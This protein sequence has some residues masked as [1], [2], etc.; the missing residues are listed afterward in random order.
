M[1]QEPPAEAATPQYPPHIK[2]RSSFNPFAAYAELP[3]GV[4]YQ[5][6]ESDEIIEILLRRHPITNLR[7]QIPALLAI[8]LPLLFIAVPLEPLGLE[9]LYQVPAHIRVILLLFWYLVVAGYA[10][11]NFLIWYFNVYFVTNKRVVDVDFNGLMHYS[12]NEVA[13]HQIQDVEHKQV[14]IWQMLFRYGTVHIQT[15]ATKQNLDF[16]KVPLPARVADIVTDLLPIPTDVIRGK[17][18]RE[19][20]VSANQ[21]GAHG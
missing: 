14:G 12:S 4:T 15:S 6:Q 16:E 19:P 17:V 20:K 18:S 9:A 8:L 7:W 5:D 10:I 1:N 3:R 2:L 13:L 11:E 21:G